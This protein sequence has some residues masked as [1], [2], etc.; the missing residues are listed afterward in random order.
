[1]YLPATEWGGPTYAIANYVDALRMAGAEAEVFTTTARGSAEYQPIEPGVRQIRGA[2]VSYFRAANGLQ[3]FIAPAMIPALRARVRQFDVVHTH[4]LWAFPGIVATRIAAHAGVPYVVTPHACLDP[5]SLAQ[6]RWMKKAFFAAF[7]NRTLRRAAAIHY[8]ADA[9]RAA[10]P[11][12]FR[13]LPSAVV[14]NPI[15]IAEFAKIGDPAVRA[16]SRDVLILGRIHRMKGFDVLVPAIRE[17]VAREPRARLV[18]AG[19]D[20]GGYRAAVETMVREAGVAAS[21]TFTGHL[22]ALART[23]ALGRAA[24]VVQPSFREN[25]GMSV[26]EAMAAGLP[27]VVSPQVNIAEDIRRAGAGLVVDRRPEALGRAI[28]ELLA[29]PARRAT[30]GERGRHWVAEAYSLRAVGV[31]LLK[32]YED[33]LSRG[34]PRRR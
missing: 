18:V 28:L 22:D 14:P 34:G 17:V 8:T 6:R 29:D 7:E 33:V 16:A 9:E 10:V 23:A 26:A 27:V 31:T 11:D 4:L 25:F 1:M 5:W 19:A 24:L 32:C 3:A 21:V 2:T 15:D 12:R 13:D 30:M 20:E